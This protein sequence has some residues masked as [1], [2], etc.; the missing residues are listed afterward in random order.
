MVP[1]WQPF[2]WC[3]WLVTLEDVVDPVATLP[4]I[5]VMAESTPIWV[6]IKGSLSDLRA[7]VRFLADG[8]LA[9]VFRVFFSL[10]S[11]YNVVWH[12]K[13]ACNDWFTYTTFNSEP[14]LNK[15]ILKFI[16]FHNLFLF[17]Y[18][19]VNVNIIIYIII[20]NWEIFNETWTIRCTTLVGMCA[21]LLADFREFA[22]MWL[23]S[24]K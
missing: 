16:Y 18:S 5:L 2:E 23:E 17:I 24:Q 20:F 12:T 8:G 1:T 14:Y 13:V 10:A 15:S 7:G 4:K 21:S 11:F 9:G 19:I 22:E 6:A 3:V